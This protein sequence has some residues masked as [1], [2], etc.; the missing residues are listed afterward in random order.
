VMPKGE[1]LPLPLLCT[2]TFGEP[3]VLGA[4]EDKDAFIERTRDALLALAPTEAR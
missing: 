3:I 1:L 2:T 4:A